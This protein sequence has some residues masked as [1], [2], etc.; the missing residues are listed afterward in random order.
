MQMPNENIDTTM[1]ASCG[2]NCKVCYKHCYHK[3]PCAG[4]MNSDKGKPEHCRK[5]KIKDCIKEKQLFYCL[6]CSEYLCKL[7][8]NL[9]KSYNKRYQASLIENSRFVQAHGLECFM[10]QQKAKYTCPKCGG[11][12]S[13]HD[14]ECV[15][16][17]R[18]W[19][20]KILVCREWKIW[21]LT[22]R[23]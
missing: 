11:I 18:K 19:C 23:M 4:C 17:K 13:I 22:E 6:E 1:F 8:I 9:E 2:M 15:N 3:K 14:R 5:C 7:I 16:V 20:N 21:K 12:I 10:E